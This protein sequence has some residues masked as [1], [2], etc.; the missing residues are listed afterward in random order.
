[1]G[2]GPAKCDGTE[3]ATCVFKTLDLAPRLIALKGR[4]PNCRDIGGRIG[5]GGRRIRQG[6]VFR[7]AGLNE[8]PPQDY[9]EKDEILALYKAGKLAGTQRGHTPQ[10]ACKYVVCAV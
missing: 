9:Y 8:N 1:M 10:R 4:I 5:L 3:R 6:L 7:S 2:A